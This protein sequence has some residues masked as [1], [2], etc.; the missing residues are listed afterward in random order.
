[1]IDYWHHP[2]VCLSVH[3]SVCLWRCALWLS[4]LVY[5]TKSC[6]S[7]FLAHTF[8]FVPSGTFA[9]HEKMFNKQIFSMSNSNIYCQNIFSTHLSIYDPS[10]QRACECLLQNDAVCWLLTA[11]FINTFSTM[12]KLLT[13]N[14]SCWSCKTLITMYWID[15]SVNGISTNS[16][17]RPQKMT[18]CGILPVAT[19]HCM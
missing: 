8:L 7:V 10:Y 3:L 15:L 11:F 14:M 13:P 5:T 19:S 12:S 2:V 6:T 17:W 16:F 9:S 4:R 1:M 18:I